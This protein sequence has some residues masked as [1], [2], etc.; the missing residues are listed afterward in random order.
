MNNILEYVRRPCDLQPRK[1]VRV[2]FWVGLERQLCDTILGALTQIDG[3]VTIKRVTG[4][5][6]S[7]RNI[8]HP[9]GVIHLG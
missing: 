5:I 6:G 8:K 7:A 3:E 2:K 1:V 4:N 9:L